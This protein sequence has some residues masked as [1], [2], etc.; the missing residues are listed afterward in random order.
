MRL[1]KRFISAMERIFVC[2]SFSNEIVVV[3]VQNGTY[4]HNN[5]KDTDNVEQKGVSI[6][7]QNEHTHF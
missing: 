5:S 2:W 4:F 1:V 7:V 6:D 3:V